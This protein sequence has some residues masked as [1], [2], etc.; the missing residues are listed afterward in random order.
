[1][2]RSSGRPDASDGRRR[3]RL[4]S[5][6]AGIEGTGDRRQIWAVGD[7]SRV[8]I[9]LSYERTLRLTMSA[10]MHD[11]SVADQA[12]VMGVE[13]NEQ[14][15][16]EVDLGGKTFRQATFE[17]PAFALR[18]KSGSKRRGV[19]QKLGGST[20]I[21]TLKLPGTRKNSSSSA[22]MI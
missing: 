1:M 9:H 19:D 3:P 16:G 7:G 14:K 22:E 17:L 18:R 5:G 2:W 21:N 15:V 10:Q 20:G 4:E 11:R 8:A 12:R 6:W 13:L